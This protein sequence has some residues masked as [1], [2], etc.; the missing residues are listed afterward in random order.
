VGHGLPRRP[1]GERAGPRSGGRLPRR[2]APALGEAGEGPRLVRGSVR[3][4]DRPPWTA[5]VGQVLEALSRSAVSERTLVVATSDHGGE[6]RRARLLLRHGENLFDPS[7]RIPLVVAGPG[8]KA[9]HRSDV[10]ATTP[11]P[12]A[13]RPRRPEGLVP[14]GPRR[15]EASCRRPAGRGGRSGRASTARTTG[16]SWGPGTALQDRGHP[17]G[18]G[19]ALRPLRP[20]EG[21]RRDEGRRTVEPGE[22]ARGAAGPRALPREDRT[23]SL[24]RTRRLLE[25]QS[26]EERLSPDACEKLKAMG[27]VQQGCS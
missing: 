13:D 9:G 12:R 17:L 3:R 6:P 24:V 8:V 18:R 16:T 25:G 20:G 23:A 11:R 5:E 26:G 19:R 2:R 27:Y 10:L 21:P 1:G 4:R 15:R 7:M 14:A 22:D